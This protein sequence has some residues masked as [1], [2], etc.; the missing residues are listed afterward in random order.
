VENFKRTI[1]SGREDKEDCLS[2]FPDAMIKYPN[3]KYPNLRKERFGLAHRSEYIVHEVGREDS[4]EW[5]VCCS[6]T[7][8]AAYI[9]PGE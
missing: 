7:P 3:I 4:I 6:S 5:N 9:R 2:S 8:F 1:A